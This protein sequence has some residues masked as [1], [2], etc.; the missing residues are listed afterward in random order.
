MCK[1]CLN[2]HNL[3]AKIYSS[4][5][6]VLNSIALLFPFE[7][8]VQKQTSALIFQAIPIVVALCWLPFQRNSTKSTQLSGHQG[9][10]ALHLLHAG[11]GLVWQLVAVLYVVRDPELPSRVLALLTSGWGNEQFGAYF[12]LID[13]LGL[14]LC[15]VYLAAIED[16]VSIAL[17]VVLGAIVFGPAFTVSCYFVYR[18]QLI[19]K[20]AGDALSK[21]K[22]WTMNLQ[23]VS[24]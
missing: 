23:K 2:I 3:L 13:V 15:F 10:I 20:S 9:V 8:T 19:S 16:G 24:L 14:F 12:L 4:F 18:E 21:K 22:Q 11:Y 17:C 7:S 6:Q 5:I 1:C